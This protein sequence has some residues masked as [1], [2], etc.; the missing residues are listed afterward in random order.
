M[1]VAKGQ[2][3]W[4]EQQFVAGVQVSEAA[5]E[6]GVSQ[7]VEV[8]QVELV[9]QTVLVAPALLLASREQH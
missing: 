7:A 2:Q 5:A 9:V 3:D 4:K 8:Q 1:N 6:A